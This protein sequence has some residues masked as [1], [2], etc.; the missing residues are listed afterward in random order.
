M[1]TEMVEVA[2]IARPSEQLFNNH[3]L[4]YKTVLFVLYCT[5]ILQHQLF[6]SYETSV[7][8]LRTPEV[9]LY[10]STNYKLLF[11]AHITQDK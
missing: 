9:F 11:C 8:A 5:S 4:Q 1:H 3:Y 7:G 10:Q 2:P 6:P